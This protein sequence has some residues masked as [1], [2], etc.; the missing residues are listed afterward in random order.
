MSTLKD[1]I[2]AIPPDGEF[3]DSYCEEYFIMMAKKM[4]EKGFTKEETLEILAGFYGAVSGE[5]GN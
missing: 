3:W 5:F 4:T 1:D 2:R